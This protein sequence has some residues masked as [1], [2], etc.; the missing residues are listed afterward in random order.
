M[1]PGMVMIMRLIGSIIVLF[2]PGVKRVVLTLKFPE[3]LCLTSYQWI[4]GLLLCLGAV[5]LT[6]RSAAFQA[7]LQAQL[8]RSHGSRALTSPPPPWLRCA[9]N[10][11]DPRVAPRAL[12][13]RWSRRPLCARNPAR[14][15]SEARA[16]T[17]RRP[18]WPLCACIPAA[19]ELNR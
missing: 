3:P 7:F 10:P 4:K 18:R 8:L 12:T 19:R 6:A 13:S 5:I 16:L 17:S 9:C 14:T 1:M 15:R 11:A 2:M